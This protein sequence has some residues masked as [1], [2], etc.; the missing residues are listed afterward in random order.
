MPVLAGPET[1]RAIRA[2]APEV[3]VVLMTAAPESS[4]AQRP[5]ASGLL[6]KPFNFDDLENMV[7]RFT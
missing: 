4:A 6:R 3:P 5:E 7:R 1:L 2:R